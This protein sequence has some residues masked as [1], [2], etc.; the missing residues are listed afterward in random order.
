MDMR[1]G[2]PGAD[3]NPVSLNGTA[4]AAMPTARRPSDATGSSDAHSAYSPGCPPAAVSGVG[5]SA[6]LV[7]AE[8]LQAILESGL[9]SLDQLIA[10]RRASQP[11]VNPDP[12]SRQQVLRL[13]PKLESMYANARGGQLT[14]SYFC[15]YL[16][17]AVTLSG[18][19]EIHLRYPP[20]AVACVS[21][22]FEEAI[23]RCTAL[24]R[25]DF[26]PL[27][28][29]DRVASLKMLHS[30]V[31]YLLGVLDAQ[32]APA[33]PDTDGGVARARRVETAIENAI[34]TA[35]DELDRTAAFIAQAG[36][37]RAL[38]NYMQAI[39]VGI[40][41]LVGLG[42][43]LTRVPVLDLNL[44]LTLGILTAGSA[45]A[46]VSVMSRL[47]S[48][49]FH[50]DERPGSFGVFLAG[51]FRP[52]LGALFGVALYVFVGSGI[53]PAL[54]VPAGEKESLFFYAIAFLAGFSERFA[55]DV[56]TSTEGVIVPAS[57]P[58]GV[59]NPVTRRRSRTRG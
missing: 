35:N 2:V 26:T 12:Q 10:A 19:H 36:R 17:A 4:F 20:E 47:T 1:V 13:V 37:R 48:N 30:L 32:H 7:V 11:N 24:A 31:V 18:N 9:V 56:I 3:K 16:G 27:D 42:V 44:A 8:D 52:L 53:F 55:A 28:A 5:T 22:E 43:L 25:H 15:R 21:P 6:D 57:R 38:R 29:Q 23:W 50:I 45:G 41:G 58:A 46:I 49:K 51:A 40:V 34:E 39:P 54:T 14:D 33:Q 59:T